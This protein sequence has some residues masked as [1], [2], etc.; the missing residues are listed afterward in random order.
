MQT[1]FITLEVALQP[2]AQ[3]LHD[4]ILAELQQQGEPLRWAIVAVD[5]E[6]N[7]A[8]IEAVITTPTEFL[9]PHTA[10]KTV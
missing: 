8:C 5:R 1:H 9:I 4:R 7:I 6:R 2:S 10:V 3:R